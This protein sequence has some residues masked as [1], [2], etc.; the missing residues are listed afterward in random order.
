MCFNAEV[1][2]S[3]YLIG[4]FGCLYLF[5]KKY[6]PE[7]IF[8]LWVIHMQLIEFLLWNNQPCN[9]ENQNISKIGMI[10]NNMEPMILWLAIIFFSKKKLPSWVHNVMIVFLLI[11]LYIS[12]KSYIKD[13]CTIVTI[14][15][16][17]HLNWLWNYQSKYSIPY[18]LLFVSIFMLLTIYGLPF[19]YHTGLTL[20]ISFTISVIIYEKS[21]VTGSMWCFF[22]AFIPFLL[23]T[24]YK[25]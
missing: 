14:D 1:S 6:I 20:L 22:S 3:T 16:Y 4:V 17:P 24:I 15:S 23:P 11:T 8:F 10:V 7:A 19:G 5:Q 2:I 12:Y 21:N 13:N 9:N 18:Y 25:I